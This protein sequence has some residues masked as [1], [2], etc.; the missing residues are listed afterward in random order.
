MAKFVDRSGVVDAVQLPVETPPE[1][2]EAAM[3]SGVVMMTDAGFADVHQ[4]LAAPKAGVQSSSAAGRV[5]AA[6]ATLGVT[7]P[8]AGGPLDAEA[9]HVPPG[10]KDGDGKIVPT[11]PNAPAAAGKPVPITKADPT[12]QPPYMTAATLTGPA[13]R[14]VPGDWIVIDLH[15]DIFI[16]SDADFTRI[17]EPI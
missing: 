3:K 17:Y 9:Q 16:A 2:L 15:G 14:A 1:W 5:Y 11:G 6:Q 13:L 8:T 4:S 12:V 10:T 7:H